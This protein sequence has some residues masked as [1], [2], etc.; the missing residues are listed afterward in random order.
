MTG[1]FSA[2]LAPSEPWVGAE[3][4]DVGSPPSR[5]KFAELRRPSSGNSDR[6]AY[7]TGRQGLRRAGKHH[8]SAV[9]QSAHRP[10][11][12][13]HRRLSNRPSLTIAPDRD[14]DANRQVSPSRQA[15]RSACEHQ[16]DT[17]DTVTANIPRRPQRTV[18]RGQQRPR[19]GD[20][21]PVT[22]SRERR[23]R[24]GVLHR[25]ATPPTTSTPAR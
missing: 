19:V 14:P 9:P 25:I 12:R 17:I 20:R 21:H 11:L 8:T 3:M 16:R 18:A 24:G 6:L 5:K 2:S 4:T 1:S 22:L 23:D 15:P 7:A 10:G 13:G